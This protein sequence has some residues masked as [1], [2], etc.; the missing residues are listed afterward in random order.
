MSILNVVQLLVSYLSS[1][2]CTSSPVPMSKSFLGTL[3]EDN[4]VVV[5][6]CSRCDTLDTLETTRGS[7][8]SALKAS[9]HGFCIF[10]N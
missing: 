10:W 9:G 2:R 8:D 7:A 1:K 5:V 4:R 6:V 3:D